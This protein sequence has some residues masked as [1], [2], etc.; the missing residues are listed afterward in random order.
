MITDE[1]NVLQDFI[2]KPMTKVEGVANAA[3]FACTRNTLTELVVEQESF[4]FSAEFLPK[5]KKRAM[6]YIT[7]KLHIDIGSIERLIQA[8][9]SSSPIIESIEFK[10]NWYDNY[11]N[12]VEV[13]LHE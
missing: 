4:D 7:D 2:E 9:K 10:G 6:V 1:D 11:K 3:I 5:L 12:T 8:N 13:F